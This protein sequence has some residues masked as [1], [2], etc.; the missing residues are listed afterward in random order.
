[1]QTS[2][3]HISPNTEK[4]TEIEKKYWEFLPKILGKILGFFVIFGPIYSLKHWISELF[5]QYVH[6]TWGKK[7]NQKSEQVNFISIQFISIP[8]NSLKRAVFGVRVVSCN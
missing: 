7:S 2:H 4:N 1:M 8:T 5:V 6:T 3:G